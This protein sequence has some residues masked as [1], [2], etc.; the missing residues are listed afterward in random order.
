MPPWAL[1]VVAPGGAALRWCFVVWVVGA[2]SGWGGLA[3]HYRY[4]SDEP[5]RGTLRRFRSGKLGWA[6]SSRCLTVGTNPR[7]LYLAVFVLFRPGHPPL[8]VPW[9]ELTARV[10]RV[11]IFGS[12]LDLTFEKYPGVVVRLPR[13]LGKEIAADANRAW[14]EEEPGVK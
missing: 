9:A 6:N 12:W 11:W 4:L 5:F 14:A 8:F 7:G 3:R 13:R 10:V 1:A 2:L